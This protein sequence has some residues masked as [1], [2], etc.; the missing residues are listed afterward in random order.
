LSPGII[1]PCR[2][3][4]LQFVL[5]MCL[6][7]CLPYARTTAQSKLGHW[8][9]SSITYTS[10]SESPVVK[11]TPGKNSFG[12]MLSRIIVVPY[13]FFISDVDGDHC[14]FAPSCSAFFMESCSQ[15]NVVQGTLMF[16]DRFTR[17][18]NIF[19]REDHYRYDIKLHR[20]Y[21]P[22]VN[23]RLRDSLIIL[24]PGK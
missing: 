7:L 4:S 13:R 1:M 23:Y 19:D 21:D 11:H 20:Y 2:L 12:R 24:I 16:F 9:A 15:T 6:L 5:T 22:S 10:G 3:S 18:A 8:S 14:P 17:D